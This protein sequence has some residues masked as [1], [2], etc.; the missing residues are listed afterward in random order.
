MTCQ[1]NE[2]KAQEQLSQKTQTLT[3]KPEITTSLTQVISQGSKGTWVI[4][5]VPYGVVQALSLYVWFAFCL[6]VPV[7]IKR[8]AAVFP[9]LFL[10]YI[11]NDSKN[12]SSIKVFYL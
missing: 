1:K 4:S 10:P 7:W 2:F 6:C 9:A 5:K 8:E 3:L 11:L 12:D